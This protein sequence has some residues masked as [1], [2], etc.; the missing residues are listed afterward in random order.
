MTNHKLLYSAEI[1]IKGTLLGVDFV[2]FLR[3]FI[4]QE[5]ESKFRHHQERS[6]W[7]DFRQMNITTL[8]MPREDQKRH[9]TYSKFP[10]QY[11]GSEWLTNHNI[12]SKIPPRFGLMI[13]EKSIVTEAMRNK[14]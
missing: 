10:F 12:W 11:I 8:K 6:E 1:G 9:T 3:I 13:F 5:M 7:M 2:K 14:G 4:F